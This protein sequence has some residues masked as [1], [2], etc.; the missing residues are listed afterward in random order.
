M[1]ALRGWGTNWKDAGKPTIKET[2]VEGKGHLTLVM[3]CSIRFDI[4][5]VAN[6]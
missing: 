3:L 1:K 5:T 2:S 6:R 4:S